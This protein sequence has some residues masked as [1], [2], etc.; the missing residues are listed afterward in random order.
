VTPNPCVVGSNPTGVARKF[1]MPHSKQDFLDSVMVTELDT[2]PMEMWE[3]L[4][5][6]TTFTELLKPEEDFWGTTTVL[7][8]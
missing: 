6:Q 2:I 7:P 8:L 4:E 3:E 1:T 5:A